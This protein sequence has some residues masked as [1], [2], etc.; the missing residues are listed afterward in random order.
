MTLE[1]LAKG[2]L[3]FYAPIFEVEIEG[4]K[5]DAITSNEITFVKVNEKLDEG[6]SFELTLYNEFNMNTQTFKLIDDSRFYVGNEI[7]IKMGYENN[8]HTMIK[9]KVTSLE[10]SF[11]K[12]EATTLTIKGYDPSYDY[13][14][15]ATPEK[16]FVDKT[17]SDIARTIAQEAGLDCEVDE[18]GE[19]EKFIRKN[20]NETYYAFLYNIK[21]KVGFNFDIKEQKMYFVK[22]KDKKKEILTLELGKDIISFH[23]IMN[24]SR[25]LAEIEVRGHNLQDPNTAFIGKAKAE[26]ELLALLNKIGSKDFAKKVITDVVVNSKEHAEKIANAELSKASYTFIEGTVECIGLPQIRTGVNI[27]LNK[28]GERFSNK[29]Y[30]TETTHTIDSSGYR[31]LFSV[32]S[33]SVKRV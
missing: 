14:K 15:R 33:N 28:V 32:K 24:T 30:V 20:N 31:T 16:T 10:P 2:N 5:L 8:L 19:F 18:T 22:P 26:G 13:M 3:N 17:Y 4:K 6:A 29:Y 11:S 1:T 21:D 23:P 27:I 12:N 9:G 7:I 25:L